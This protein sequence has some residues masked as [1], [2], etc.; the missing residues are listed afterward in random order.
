MLLAWAILSERPSWGE[1]GGMVLILAG[2]FIVSRAAPA[3]RA[4]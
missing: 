3:A 2:I 4:S 1:V